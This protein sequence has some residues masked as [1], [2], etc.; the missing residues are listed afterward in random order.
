MAAR[1]LLVAHAATVGT[2]VGVFGDR[3]GLARPEALRPLVGV[4]RGW[5]CG[6]EPACLATA[7]GL[8][9]TPEVAD[10]LAGPDA[11]EWAGCSLAEVGARDPDR[12]H[13]WLA[14]PDAEPPGG[15]SL[16]G[17][18]RRVGVWLDSQPWPA[19]RSVVVVTPLTARALAVHAL[20]AAPAVIYRLDVAPED[21]LTLSRSGAV[22]RLGLPRRPR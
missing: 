3:T 21:R 4:A 17:L 14:D 10:A 20:G 12:L 2:P 5:W 15:E 16:S 6:P 13:A 22:W 9:G 18:I 11:G 1:V 8:G 19:G 7:R